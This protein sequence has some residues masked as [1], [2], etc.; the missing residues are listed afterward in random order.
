[1]IVKLKKKRKIELIQ[2][3]SF[4]RNKIAG[5]KKNVVVNKFKPYVPINEV[6]WIYEVLFDK[7]YTNKFHGNPDK[8]FPLK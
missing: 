3:L 8:I 2:I 7:E 5:I 6:I 1:M 4:F